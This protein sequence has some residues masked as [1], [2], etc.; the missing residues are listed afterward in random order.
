MTDDT[1][2]SAAAE[3]NASAP[4]KSAGRRR[5]VVLGVIF[6]V[7]V[8]AGIGG[9]IWHEQPSFCNAFCHVPMDAYYATYTA[10][11]DLPTVDK[12]GNSVSDS[13]AMLAVTH[14]VEGE[15]CLACHVPTIGEMVSEGLSWVPGNYY[16]PLSERNLSD[17]TAARKIDDDK[18][19]LNDDCHHVASDGS[20]IKTRDDLTAATAGLGFNVHDPHHDEYACSD[21]HK[22]HRASV[23]ICSKPGCH[24]S[25][26]LPEGWL[27]YPESLQ[28]TMY[29]NDP[30]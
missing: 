23:N 1:G 13:A 8:C 15:D 27:S 12:Y 22:A 30:E 17:L 21:C 14:R 6:A 26:P 20:A 29:L 3:T 11:L 2:V 19:C 16:F 24:S 28:I 4:R 9:W 18:F 7:L 25:A 10:E 5:L